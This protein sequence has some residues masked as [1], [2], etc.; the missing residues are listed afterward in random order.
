[1]WVS[2]RDYEMDGWHVR[3][4]A[5]RTI[6]CMLIK[7]NVRLGKFECRGYVM[8]CNGREIVF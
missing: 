4:E 7:T 5:S 3:L 1:V 6:L 2:R 8:A